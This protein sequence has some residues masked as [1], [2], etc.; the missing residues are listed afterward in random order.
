MNRK[1]KERIAARS[2]RLPCDARSPIILELVGRGIDASA[3]G[4]VARPFPKLRE[5]ATTATD[6]VNFHDDCRCR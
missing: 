6:E 4:K 2:T 1:K 5:T 3:L